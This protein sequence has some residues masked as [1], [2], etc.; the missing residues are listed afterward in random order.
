MNLNFNFARIPEIHFGAGQLEKLPTFILRY[1][2]KIIVLT[3]SQSFKK[4]A[5][6]EALINYLNEYSID[7]ILHE[8]SGEPSPDDI[9]SI[10][11][12]HRKDRIDV[13]VAIG[14]GSVLDAG[15]A[16]SAMVNKNDPVEAYLEGVGTKSHDG[17]KI[18]FIAVPTTSGT[19]SEATKNAVLTQLGDKGFKKSLRHDNFIPDIALIDPELTISCPVH[20]TAACGMD[21]F[22]QLL[23]SYV[24][25]KASPLTDAL[26]LSGLKLMKDCL[27]PATKEGVQDIV[28]RTGL[29]Y[30]ALLSGMTLANAGLGIVH[31]LASSVGS[32]FDIPHGV[33]CGTLVGVSTKINIDI[34]RRNK[35]ENESALKKYADIGKLLSSDTCQDVDRCCDSL[36]E[37]IEEWIQGLQIPRLGAYGLKES[38][39]EKVANGTGQKNNPVRLGKDDIRKIIINRL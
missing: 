9:N 37:K 18:P 27:I 25:T 8:I 13:V 30:G 2:R 28:I 6:F 38:D 36:V 15:K 4:S 5:G 12:V 3:G 16:V 14:G 29:S 22:T 7:P 1:G 24:S 26:V 31:G 35:N 21:A 34:L 11:S 33:V 20:I 19:G 39:I 32:Y 23:E 17:S 10:C